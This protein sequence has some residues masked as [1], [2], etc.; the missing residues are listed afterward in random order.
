MR[1]RKT[2]PV[3]GTHSALPG[4]FSTS[5][6]DRTN[7]TKRLIWICRKWIS[8]TKRDWSEQ[9]TLLE[10]TLNTLFNVLN[11]SCIVMGW[12]YVSMELRSLT[13]PLS[14][15]QMIHEWIWSSG[16]MI[17]QGKTEELGDKPVPVP[18]CSLQTTHG[19]TWE[20]TRA[21]AVRSGLLT[22]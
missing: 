12:V 13:V 8:R 4:E 3:N 16:A 14:I 21:S 7:E 19:L 18:L 17:W 5:W 6:V 20:W 2:A 22:A 15:P 1:H 10:Y 9:M 11:I